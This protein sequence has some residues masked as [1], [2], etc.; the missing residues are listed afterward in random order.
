MTIVSDYSLGDI[1]YL[2]T[3]IDQKE[4]IIVQMSIRPTGTMY[5]LGCGENS[6]WHYEIEFGTSRDILKVTS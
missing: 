4:R 6:S 2:K 5:E 3:D 1:V